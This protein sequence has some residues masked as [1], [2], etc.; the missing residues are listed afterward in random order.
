MSC[1][2]YREALSAR[3]D[4]EQ[5]GLPTADLDAHLAGCPDCAGWQDAAA[6]ATRLVRLAPAPEVPDLSAAVLAAVP[7]PAPAVR[8]RG[9]SRDLVGVLLR[10]GLVLV[11]IGQ[12]AVGWPALAM[13]E[14]TMGAPLHVAHESGSW[15]LALAVALLAVA[16][17]PR[18]AAGL[19]PLLTAFVGVL[20]IFS[21]PD[22]VSGH[23]PYDRL[24]DHLL[25]VGGLVMVAALA[26]HSRGPAT[27]PLDGRGVT[28]SDS[29]AGEAGE[30]GEPVPARP[31]WAGGAQAAAGGDV[32]AGGTERVVA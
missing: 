31:R 14:E 28:G 6:R 29:G 13:G 24:A 26:H 17:R 10:A 19:V 23:V 7:V 12:A 5:A 15:N 3:L 16:R 4:G 21:V 18:Y 30:A 20:A 27:G 11:A 32:P 25:L 9:V 2:R 22:I 8:F 1:D